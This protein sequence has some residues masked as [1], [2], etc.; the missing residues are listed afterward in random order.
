MV[1]IDIKLFTIP[2]VRDGA[3]STLMQVNFIAGT[4]HR[5]LEVFSVCDRIH[6]FVGIMQ[7]E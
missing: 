7:V 6:R 2:F 3:F 4:F 5:I 1:R